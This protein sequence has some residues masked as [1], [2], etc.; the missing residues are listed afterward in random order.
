MT[1]KQ[2]LT[3]EMTRLG[4]CRAVRFLGYNVKYGSRF[5]GTLAKVPRSRCIET[6]VAENLIMGLAMGMSLEGYKPIVCFERMDFMLVA[7]DSII[8]HLS[9][10]PKL[11]GGQFDFPVTIRCCVG[12]D[13][14]LDPGIQHKRDYSTLFSQNTSIN[15]WRLHDIKD[16]HRAYAR[17]PANNE[18]KIYVEYREFYNVEEEG[19]K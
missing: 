19:G 4:K 2:A 11:S 10:L 12:N 9:A 17:L 15:M 1:Y 3:D 14:P 18:P 5:Y 6:P 7:A 13:H 8:N 16:I